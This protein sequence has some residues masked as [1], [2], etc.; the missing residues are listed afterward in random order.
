M[1]FVRGDGL[2][3]RFPSVPAIAAIDPDVPDAYSLVSA[4]MP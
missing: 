3:A 2:A 4:A 1:N